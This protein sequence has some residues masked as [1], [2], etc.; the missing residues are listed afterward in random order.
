MKLINV[1]IFITLFL[2]GC[3]SDHIREIIAGLPVYNTQHIDTY[4]EPWKA[5][6]TTWKKKSLTY[7]IEYQP[8][9]NNGK[10]VK[11]YFSDKEKGFISRESTRAF[12]DW[13]QWIGTT[14]V[15]VQNKDA[16]DFVFIW[17]FLENDGVGKDKMR[18]DFP[19]Y[20]EDRE[21]PVLIADLADMYDI[22]KTNQKAYRAI[23][24]HEAGHI[25]G[26]Q[27]HTTGYTLMDNRNRYTELQIDDIVGIKLTYKDKSDFVY[28]NV[29]YTYIH[30]GSTAYQ[31]INFKER[32]FLSKCALP[33]GDGHY[34]SLQVLNAI[35]YIRAYYGCPIKILSSFRDIYCNR[36]AGGATFSQHLFRNALDW[37]FVGPGAVA[38]QR[39]YEFD[40][41]YKKLPLSTLLLLGIE[42]FGSYPYGIGTN[43]IDS[44]KVDKFNRYYNNKG[45]IVWGE[46]AHGG[47]WYDWSAEFKSHD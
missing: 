35:Q 5:G 26:S 12:N 14:V 21:K 46:F 31:T 38:A 30:T 4:N 40:I 7:Y 29:T 9:V 19:P 47:A 13:G 28:Q 22:V 42:G 17:K 23:I 27:Q 39:K 44:R 41:N 37:K 33:N 32:E 10:L 8:A 24:L 18:S 6:Y 36:A 1:L 45:Y 15:E 16:A 11:D 25:I 34:L 20:K 2:S 43:H 3:K